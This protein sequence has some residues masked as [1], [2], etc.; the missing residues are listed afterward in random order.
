MGVREPVEL[1]GPLGEPVN[2]A[3][4]ALTELANPSVK[5]SNRTRMVST[6]LLLDAD[7]PFVGTIYDSYGSR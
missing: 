2:P 7:T 6:N 5:I 1:L 3:T 4:H